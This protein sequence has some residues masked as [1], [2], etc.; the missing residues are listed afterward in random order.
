[1]MHFEPLQHD[2]RELAAEADALTAA[3]AQLPGSRFVVGQFCVTLA[4]LLDRH[5]GR[6]HDLALEEPARRTPLLSSLLHEHDDT[7]GYLHAIIRL[8]SAA[9]RESMAD[10]RPLIEQ[11]VARLREQCREQEADLRIWERQA[12]E[13]EPDDAWMLGLDSETMVADL[14]QALPASRHS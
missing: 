4:E 5:V 1:M 9:P 2:H 7:R 12:K 10:L 3:V 11:W 13:Q 6:E 8:W 14:L